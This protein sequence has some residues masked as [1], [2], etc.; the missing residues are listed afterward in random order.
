MCLPEL[1][2]QPTEVPNSDFAAAGSIHGTYGYVVFVTCNKGYTG[3]G[4][5]VCQTSGVFSTPHCQGTEGFCRAAVV[6]AVGEGQGWYVRGGCC[7]GVRFGRHGLGGSGRGGRGGRG[8]DVLE[9][10][11]TVG[12]GGGTPPPWTPPPLNP[13]SPSNV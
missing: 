7:G 12:R 11:Y 10:P 2:C 13:P 4:L 5:A 1:P 8:S 9:R 6:E 3:S